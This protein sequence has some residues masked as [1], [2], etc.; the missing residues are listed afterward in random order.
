V[1]IFF[2]PPPPFMG[3][4]QPHAPRELPP[5]ITAVPV[6]NPPFTQ[7][8]PIAVI[9]E[10][11]AIGQP[12][13]WQYVFAGPVAGRQPYGPRQLNPS[14]TAVPVNN[15]PFTYGG[16]IALLA[17]EAAIAQPDPW[18]YN[19]AGATQP[20][21]PKKNSPGIPGQSADPPPFTHRGLVPATAEEIALT[22]PDPWTYNFAGGWQPFQPRRLPASI[23]AVPV[24]DPPFGSRGSAQLASIIAQAQPD[25][26]VY[27]F[28]GG[29]QPFTPRKVT[30]SVTYL[31]PR[32]SAYVIN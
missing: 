26:W 2:P 1:A 32:T 4:A 16:P 11:V 7:G 30:V 13:P 29:W 18:T 31:T 6:N 9:A 14:I 23:T 21:T 25:P 10:V 19:F 5:S 12:N 22:Q 8:G 24:N 15:P 27:A 20:F 17:E 3:G 28:M